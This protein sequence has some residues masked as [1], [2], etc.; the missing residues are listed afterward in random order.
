VKPLLRGEWQEG[1]EAK[2]WNGGEVENR[3]LK[4][5]LRPRLDKQVL[6]AIVRKIMVGASMRKAA[7]V[8]IFFFVYTIVLFQA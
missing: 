2:R 3:R 8:N 6:K 5:W 1:S 4:H 7:R